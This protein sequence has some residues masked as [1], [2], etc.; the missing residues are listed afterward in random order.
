MFLKETDKYS[1]F[2]EKGIPTHDHEG[3]ELSKGLL[4]KLAKD[5][6]KQEKLHSDYL[7]SQ[8]K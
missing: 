3:K 5:Y 2:D 8:K 7:L 1:K 6:E 4:K